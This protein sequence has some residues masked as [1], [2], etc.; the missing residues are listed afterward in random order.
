MIK[1]LNRRKNSIDTQQVEKAGNKKQKQAL[2]FHL[3]IKFKFW[4][5]NTTNKKQELILMPFTTLQ[6]KIGNSRC[7]NHI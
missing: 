6:S 5:N 7:Q 4:R 2:D 1:E 3:D